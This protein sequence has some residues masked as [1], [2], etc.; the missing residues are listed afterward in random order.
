MNNV[1]HALSV[2]PK[3]NDQHSKNTLQMCNLMQKLYKKEV[4]HVLVKDAESLKR[5]YT[6]Q[7]A[8]RKLIIHRQLALRRWSE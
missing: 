3:I 8:G 1:Q 7:H 2:L 5:R 4:S 6:V